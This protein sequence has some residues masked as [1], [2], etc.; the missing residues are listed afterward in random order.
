MLAPYRAQLTNVLNTV[1]GT[2]NVPVLRGDACGQSAGR[3]CESLIGDVVTDAMRTTYSTDFAVTN[4]GGLRAA[5]TCPTVDNPNDFCPAFVPPPY[6]ITNG[7]IFGVLP[8]GNLVST[9]TLNGAEL[10]AMLESGV[11]AMPAV[12]GRFPQVSGLCFTYDIA[13]PVSSR[14]TGAVRQAVDGSCTGAAVDL[15]SATSY[16]VAM[17]DFMA[18][19]GDGYPNVFSKSVTLAPLDS[20]ATDYLTAAGTIGPVIQGRIV[21]ADSNGA[22]VAPTCPTILP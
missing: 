20:V 5:L 6:P 14:V 18:S 7:Q 8:F 21:C 19:G 17:N 11:S 10:R 22:G 13:S 9:A 3:T 12:E 2:S 15:T 1:V 4:S 16:L